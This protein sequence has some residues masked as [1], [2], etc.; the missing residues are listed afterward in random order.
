MYQ[1]RHNGMLIASGGN[2]E[3][4]E[5]GLHFY[6]DGSEMLQW[7]TMLYPRG[8]VLQ[9]H[10]HKK[11]NRQFKYRTHE[12]LFVIQGVVEAKFYSLD[13][14]PITTRLLKVGDFVCLYNGGHGF[15]VLEDNTKMIEVK[16]GPFMGVGKD[17]IK[18]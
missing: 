17:K 11:I 5:G 14:K 2:V 16:H 10:I 6:G 3:D 8:T 15:E 18:F 1:I 12:F 7:A 9:P 4:I 13:K